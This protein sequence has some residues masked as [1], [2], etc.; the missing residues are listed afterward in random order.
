MCMCIHGVS[1]VRH[2]TSAKPVAA[3]V[4]HDLRRVH[5]VKALRHAVESPLNSPDCGRAF[6]TPDLDRL[7]EAADFRHTPLTCHR[8]FIQQR[9]EFCLCLRPS[10]QSGQSPATQSRHHA[11]KQQAIWRRGLAHNPPG[12]NAA[13][14]QRDARAAQR[15]RWFAWAGRLKLQSGSRI[16]ERSYKGRRPA[17]HRTHRC[18]SSRASA[19][20]R[21]QRFMQ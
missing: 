2:Y 18:P 4:R 14:S 10:T 3:P 9:P 20:G 12:R 7:S 6:C 17:M 21:G 16:L 5:T 19:S 1:S 8:T 15:G 11:K 13:G